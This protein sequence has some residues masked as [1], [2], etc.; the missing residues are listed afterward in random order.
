MLAALLNPAQQALVGARSR[1]WVAGAV[2]VGTVLINSVLVSNPLESSQPW[3][4]ILLL[5]LISVLPAWIVWNSFSRCQGVRTLLQTLIV[6]RVSPIWYVVALALPVGISLAGMALLPLFG[7]AL[8]PWPRTEPIGALLPL[9]ATTFVATLLY[10]G[11]LGE[12]VGWRG[13]ALPRLQA[14]FSPLVAS[15]LLSVI[16]GLWHVPL[17]LHGAY[18]GIFPDGLPGI[19]LRII[20]TVPTTILFTW[21]SNRTKGNLWLLVLLHTAVNNTAG[22]WLPVTLGVYVAMSI[23]MVILILIDRMWRVRAP[24]SALT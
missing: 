9:L 24:E 23:V 17:H 18:H 6:W 8:P 10:G 13:F 1:F 4:A 20:T 7:Q 21:F 3:L 14:R 5:L 11:P 12:E 15:L 22:F 19:L 16:W 2:L